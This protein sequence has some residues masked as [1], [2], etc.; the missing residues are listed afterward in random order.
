VGG[1]EV[2]HHLSHQCE[3]CGARLSNFPVGSA[4]REF[5]GRPLSNCRLHAGRAENA[6]NGAIHAVLAYSEFDALL[7]HVALG[8]ASVNLC[9]SVVVDKDYEGELCRIKAR[10]PS[11]APGLVRFALR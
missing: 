6:E 9:G 11:R 8:A 2:G 5:V 1:L 3:V 4:Y 7:S 10:L